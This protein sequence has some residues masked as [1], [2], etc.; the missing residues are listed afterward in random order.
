MDSSLEEGTLRSRT[1]RQAGRIS[2]WHISCRY[3]KS[4]LLQ[5]DMKAPS[6]ILVSGNFCEIQF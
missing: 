1:K 4:F 5:S 2:E 6:V 3:S